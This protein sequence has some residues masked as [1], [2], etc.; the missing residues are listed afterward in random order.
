MTLTVSCIESSRRFLRSC[1]RAFS[2]SAVMESM[3]RFILSI[4][5]RKAVGVL[6]AGPGRGRRILQLDDVDHRRVGRLSP[7]LE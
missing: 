4:N 5:N 1:S 2:I 6:S 3:N 7:K